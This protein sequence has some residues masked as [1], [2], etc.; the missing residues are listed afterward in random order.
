MGADTFREIPVNRWSSA[1]IAEYDTNIEG[2]LKGELSLE[3]FLDKLNKV[4][5]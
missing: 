2:F 4:N 1:W 5:K 3:K